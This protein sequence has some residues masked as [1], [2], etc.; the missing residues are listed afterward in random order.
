VRPWRENNA[1]AAR[2]RRHGEFIA[3]GTG[4][5]VSGGLLMATRRPLY[6]P[7]WAPVGVLSPRFGG[8]FFLVGLRKGDGRS[9][10]PEAIV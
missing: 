7:S 6:P 5:Y 1:F 2:F 9:L 10:T 4:N 8:G 3:A